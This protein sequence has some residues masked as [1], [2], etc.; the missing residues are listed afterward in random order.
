MKHFYTHSTHENMH[1]SK[2]YKQ[3]TLANK[4]K[5]RL[6]IISQVCLFMK[7]SQ[8]FLVTGKGCSCTWIIQ[9]RSNACPTS[10]LLPCS[11]F[12]SFGKSSCC[13]STDFSGRQ[14]V[15]E[16]NAL[17]SE[18]NKLNTHA[19]GRAHAHALAHAHTTHQ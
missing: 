17:F 11:I 14:Q 8:Q 9:V 15:G 5:I 10:S 18:I 2:N 12:C 7:T 3:F 6:Y 13:G 16:E 4:F 19:F 1:A